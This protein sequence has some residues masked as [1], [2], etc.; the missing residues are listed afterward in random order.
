MKLQKMLALLCAMVLF[1]AVA[2]GGGEKKGDEMPTEETTEGAEGA[3]GAATEEG[4]SEEG[5]TEEAPA[6]GTTEEAPAEGMTEEAP[7]EGDAAEGDDAV[8]ETEEEAP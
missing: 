4:A 8:E 7:A 2:C 5:T 6:E 1:G 3:G